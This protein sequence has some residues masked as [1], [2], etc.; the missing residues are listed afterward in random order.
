MAK[1]LKFDADARQ[2]LKDGVDEL[3]SAV[4]VT[5]GPTGRNVVLDK[6]FGG[7]SITK[8]GVTVAEE[9]D[10]EDR[11]E[12]LGST[13]V[14]EVASQT[15]D[16]AGDG[17]TTATVLAQS[18]FTE[19]LKSV[20]AGVNPMG[21]KRGIDAA[22]RKAI[23]E[24]RSMATPTVDKEDIVHVATI[25]ANNDPE[26]GRLIADGMEKVGREGVITVEEG[27]GLE[28]VLETVEG[29]HF[30]EGYLSPYFATNSEE[31]EAVLEDAYVLVHDEEISSMNDLLPVLEQVGQSGKPLL[32][33]ADG[34]D[35]EALA[36]LV[37]NNVKGTL[38]A[39]AVEAPGF[40][41]RQ[42]QNLRDIATVTGA[43]FISDKLGRRLEDA[44]LD[45]LGSAD[46]ITVS[47]DATT[48]VGGRGSREDIQGRIRE[49]EAEMEQTS[50]DYDREK[51]QERLARLAGGVAVI[52]V[53]AATETEMNAKKALVED[54]LHATR[55]AVEEGVLPGGGVAF[56]RVQKAL[57]GFDPGDEEE[58]LGADIV[59]RALEAPTRQI[60]ENAGVTSPAVAVE[61]IR[62]KDD[63][64]WGYDARAGEYRDMMDAGII[65]PMKV[66]RTALQNAA[67]ISGLMLTTEALVV[68]VPEEDDGD[69]APGGP[70]GG[71]PGGGGMP[72]GGMPGGGMG[73]MG[74]MM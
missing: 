42:E 37:V 46:R 58:R 4:K 71:A 39:C 52:R 38:E 66:V 65:D 21:L 15:S 63:P 69:A 44:T 13:L 74:G 57:D 62:E 36:T 61:K 20:T 50:S 30:E 16:E 5:M 3:A 73:G 26:I 72:G 7:P 47:E 9:I 19:G 48:I 12:N 25:S 68:D 8:D 51:L 14:K 53:G 18:I 55:A 31:M 64:R 11:M 35:G 59:R 32:I 43:S 29:L 54:A 40:G 33:I 56:L 23:E 17:T 22:T 27:T 6:G 34:V 41:D 45:D 1:D 60:V 49:I 28:T 10:P 67:S 70:G 24:L 2:K